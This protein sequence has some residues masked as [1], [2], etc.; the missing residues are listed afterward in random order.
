[1]PGFAVNSSLL[2]KKCYS[3]QTVS[4]FKICVN[5][6]KVIIRN[7]FF[8]QQANNKVRKDIIKNQVFAAFSVLCRH[9]TGTSQFLC[10]TIQWSV[11]RGLTNK[12]DLLKFGQIQESG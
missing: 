4:F 10:F 11:L 8:P 6:S 1:M 3:C 12:N 2:M 9:N 7:S 5:L